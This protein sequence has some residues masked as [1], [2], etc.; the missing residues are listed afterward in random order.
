LLR[1]RRK[2]LAERAG[3]P[4]YVI[5]SDRALIE[6]AMYF[7]Q[8]DAQFLAINGVGEAKLANYGEAFLQVIREYCAQQGLKP[9]EASDAAPTT[10]IIRPASRRRFHEIGELFAD[11]KTIDEIAQQYGVQRQ[12]IL[13]HL[14]RFHESGRPL[15]ADRLLTCS[16]LAEPERGRVLAAFESL[17]MQRLAPVH[18]ALS[19]AIGYDELYLLRLYFLCR[20]NAGQV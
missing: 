5:F 1:A 20:G 8:D 2:E 15:D 4:A 16:R 3:M 12:T 14:H 19:G 10:P 7:P 6:M 11:G 17:G 18:E 13:V 9:K